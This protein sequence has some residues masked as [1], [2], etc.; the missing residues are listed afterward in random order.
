MICTL[1]IMCSSENKRKNKRYYTI[2]KVPKPNRKII[3]K[4]E[5]SIPLTHKY[6]TADFPGLVQALQ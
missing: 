4:D 3:D 6:M 1:P 5:I 2:G